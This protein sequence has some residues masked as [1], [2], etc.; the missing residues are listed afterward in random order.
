MLLQITSGHIPKIIQFLDSMLS[1]V[2]SP[3]TEDYNPAGGIGDK[4]HLD[5]SHVTWTTGWDGSCASDS[6]HVHTCTWRQLRRRAYTPIMIKAIYSRG[7]PVTSDNKHHADG[8][9]RQ[10]KINQ[11]HSQSCRG[12]TKTNKK[13]LQQELVIDIVPWASPGWCA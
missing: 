13:E 12:D 1:T 7:Q 8:A 3:G 9:Q 2:K 5:K 10:N 4:S 6:T 11:C